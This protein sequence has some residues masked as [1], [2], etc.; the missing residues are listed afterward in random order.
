MEFFLSFILTLLFLGV[1]V[2]FGFYILFLKLTN[3][4]LI[5]F[6]P[7][8]RENRLKMIFII[9]SLISTFLINWLIM[10]NYSFLFEIIHPIALSM[11]CLITTYSL[12]R[13]LFLRKILLSFSEKRAFWI[14]IVLS[15]CFEI[16]Q[17]F[18]YMGKE[19]PNLLMKVAL[20]LV[21]L[22]IVV[23]IASIVYEIRKSF[24]Y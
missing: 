12:L 13:F 19:N 5:D 23:L 2:I 11:I 7:M 10:E 9:L 4:R 16:L 15:A 22:V 6:L 20:L 1:L 21:I 17:I 24:K 3:L 18:K 14:A 8:M